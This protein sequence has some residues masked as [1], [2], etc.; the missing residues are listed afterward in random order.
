MYLLLGSGRMIN[1]SWNKM[2]NAVEQFK[3]H[4]LSSLTAAVIVICDVITLFQTKRHS[5]IIL[6][7]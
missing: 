5:T 4:F 6:R 7:E 2:L 1:V 3:R